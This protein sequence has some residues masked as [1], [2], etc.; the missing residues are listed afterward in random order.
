MCLSPGSGAWRAGE[1]TERKLRSVLLVERPGS[2]VPE[3]D[4]R[5]CCLGYL[6]TPRC[7]PRI[8]YLVSFLKKMFF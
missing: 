7:L 8:H 1:V 6:G 5:M 4:G 2:E 3:E